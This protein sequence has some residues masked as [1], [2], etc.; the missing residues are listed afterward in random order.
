[1]N[2]YFKHRQ[3]I[4]HLS[5]Q[6]KD[7][8]ADKYYAG[9]NVKDLIITYN[10]N[11]S[12]SSFHL[13]LPLNKDSHALCPYCNANMFILPPSKS[14]KY[15]KELICD[16]CWHIEGKYNC[17]CRNCIQKKQDEAHTKK[18]I[19][20]LKKSSNHNKTTDVLDESKSVKLKNLSEI[21]KIY[22]GALLRV[23]PPSKSS[24]FTI[25]TMAS[26]N[27]AP[28]IIMK[29]KIFSQLLEK[30]IIFEV[31]RSGIMLELSLNIV[32]LITNK[33]D[34]LSLIYPNKIK[35]VTQDIFKLIRDIQIHE[36]IEY[37]SVIAFNQFSIRNINQALIH[38]EFYAL[39]E[40]ILENDY[41]TAQLF[42]FIY[43]GVRNYAAKHNCDILKTKPTIEIY[44]NILKYYNSAVNEHWNIKNY[45]RAYLTQPSELFKIVA[46]DLLNIN[47]ALFY[48]PI[49]NNPVI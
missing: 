48:K 4:A 19:K 25:N 39:F 43:T 26:S 6:E 42:N 44:N 16:V 37:F 24:V 10:I 21:E 8:L 40:L 5:K 31:N 46:N 35:E 9:E 30:N 13:V 49:S 20:A 47:E 17:H 3:K 28:T 7:N 22:L 32:G 36:A 18:I 29:N 1:M 45:N 12:S 11:I 15:A 27:L 2:K 14:R 33:E 38:E 34:M 23:Y 41:S